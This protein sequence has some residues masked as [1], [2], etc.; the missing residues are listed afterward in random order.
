[1]RIIIH[2]MYYLPEFGSAPI[3]MN[4]LASYLTEKWHAVEVI[5][6]IP[7]ERNVNYKGRLY[8]RESNN[9]FPVKRFWTNATPH[10]IGRLIAWNIYTI[11]TIFNMFTLRKGDVLFLRV[12]PLQLG[13]MGVLAKHLKGAKVLINVQDIHPDL[14]IESGILRNPLAIRL[15][16]RF[17]KWVYDRSEEI[18]VIS[19]GFKK[20]LQDK[21][22][23]QEKIMVIP[24]WVDTDFLRPLPKDNHIA[25]K[26]S[27]NG[28]FVVL[29]SG[30]LTI[31]SFLSMKRVL[32]VANF[33]KKDNDIMFVIVGE[34]IK[35][36]QLQEEADKLSLD[37]VIFIPFQPYHDLP[38]ILASSDVV[39]VPLDKEK[40]QVSVPSKLYNFMATGRPVLGLADSSS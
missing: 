30:T 23:T 19:K 1:M 17:E 9:G 8:I 18:V 27:L 36:Q 35:K 25:R 26:F 37:N 7:R 28:K 33:L 39:L 3:L 24:N 20:N 32:E 40:S 38:Y 12:P 5:T 6:T 2:T 10:P 22:V 21:G 14:A 31:S 15:A 29:Y 4:E 34:G 11:W 16:K 13:F